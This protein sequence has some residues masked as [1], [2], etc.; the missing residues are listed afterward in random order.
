MAKKK[1]VNKAGKSKKE[2]KEPRKPWD[3][4]DKRG[5]RA[6][7]AT[8]ELPVMYIALGSEPKTEHPFNLYHDIMSTPKALRDTLKSIPDQ[9]SKV[10]DEIIARKLTRV[11]GVGMG[12]SEFVAIG[13]AAALG[14]Y[15]DF[16][17]DAADSGEFLASQ[18]NWNL[19]KTCFVIFSGSGR[20]VDSNRAAQKARDGGAHIVAVTSV[21]F[22]PLTKISDDVIVC[23]GG[24]DTGGSD[25]FHYTTRLAAGVLLALELGERTH[26]KRCDYKSLR[27]QL[28]GIPDW[29]DDHIEEIDGRCRS[30][31]RYHKNTRSALCVGGGANLATA[32]EFAL[33]FDEM[34]HIP[35]KAM[36]PNRHIHG[37]LG[38]TD[39]RIATFII[40][41]PGPSYPWLRQVAQATIGLKTPSIGIVTENDDDIAK[42]M[43]YTVRLPDVDETIFSVAAAIPAQLIPYYC[44]VELGGINPDCQRS[45]IP[46]HARVWME[47][48]PP[49]TH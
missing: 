19:P 26:P 33:K 4:L 44:A 9:V 2:G 20:T 38:L 16:D 34:C 29:W 5:I 47:L 49:G 21:P 41:P 30:I 23:K 31:A 1:S 11:V 13:G 8:S 42:M 39:E 35:G 45:N 36:C 10:V 48:F 22:S 24:F 3:W 15:A 17:G 40:A 43:D 28:Y 27:K 14:N 18:R 37:V 7:E 12:T 25:T 46:K 32:E 6:V